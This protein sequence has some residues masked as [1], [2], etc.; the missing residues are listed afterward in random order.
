MPQ[1]Q[2][3]QR[4]Q[5][6]SPEQAAPAI[7]KIYETI[8][9]KMG[10]LPNIFKGMGNSPAVLTAYLSL[11]DAVNQ[12][13][14]SPEL[15]SEIAL[16]TAQNNHC[17]YCVAAHTAISKGHG[18]SDVQIIAARKGQ[19]SD[20]KNQAV[21]SFTKKVLDKKGGVSDEDIQELKSV[22]VNDKE[23]A[24]IVL[25][26]TLNIFTNYFNRVTDTP[27]DFPQVTPL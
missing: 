20:K 22:G 13:S 8:Q 1:Q 9:T 10:K 15:R 7:K 23:I 2:T 12:T 27:L 6:V 19:T 17:N 16:F 11:S 3:Q 14:L 24:E 4:F 21:L 26:I 25:A 18:M 5:L